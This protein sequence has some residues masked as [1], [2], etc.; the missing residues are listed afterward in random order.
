M[1]NCKFLNCTKKDLESHLKFLQMNILPT[2]EGNCGFMD[3]RTPFNVFN[4]IF[5]L[6]SGIKVRA[7]PLHEN[8]IVHS[9]G[10]DWFQEEPAE[11]W[12][13]CTDTHRLQPSHL[14]TTS[15]CTNQPTTTTTVLKSTFST[16]DPNFQ[17]QLPSLTVTSL[18]KK[19]TVCCQDTLSAS[20]SLV[21]FSVVEV[22]KLFYYILA[23]IY[24][25]KSSKLYDVMTSHF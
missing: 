7:E 3:D 1:S 23:E 17:Q 21:F 19:Q 13:K 9:P 12:L 16:A 11:L 24:M 2:D 8:T 22:M 25:Y 20:K 18:I 4:L 10:Q 5:F 15:Q 14:S 6:F